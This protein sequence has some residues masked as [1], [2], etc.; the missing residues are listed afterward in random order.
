MSDSL[1]TSN[2]NGQLKGWIQEPLH[3]TG[4]AFYFPVHSRACQFAASPKHSLPPVMCEE[5][6]LFNISGLSWT[7]VATVTPHCSSHELSFRHCVCCWGFR[8]YPLVTYYCFK[9][10]VVHVWQLT[11]IYVRTCV[12]MCHKDIQS[13]NVSCMLVNYSLL[14]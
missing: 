12:A 11:P 5:S 4:D 1:S 8:W 10:F 2:K 7:S 13:I 6:C 9:L 14:M 3:W